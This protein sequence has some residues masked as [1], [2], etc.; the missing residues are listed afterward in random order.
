[1]SDTLHVVEQYNY[2][3]WNKQRYELAPEVIGAEVIRNGPGVRDVLSHDMAVDRIRKAWS[4]VQYVSFELIHTVVE[5]ELCTIVYQADIRALDG[6]ADSI[7]SIEV[8]RVVDGRIVEVWNNSHDH[9]R[10]PEAKEFAA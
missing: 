10:W 6:T 2:E 4:G 9:G 5:G 1:M 3:I 7:A 8:F